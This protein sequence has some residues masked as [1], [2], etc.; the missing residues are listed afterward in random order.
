MSIDFTQFSK[1][2]PEEGMSTHQRRWW[3]AEDPD[4]AAAGITATMGYLHQ[5]QG[6]RL[7][8]YLISSRLYGNLAMMGIN[9]LSYNK[10]ASVQ[11]GGVK[12][13]ISFN[14]VQS[15]IDTITAKIAKNK[16]KPLFL[17][18]GGDYRQQKRAKR[19]NK[20]VEGLFYETDAYDIGTSAFRDAAVFG[21]GIIHVFEKN[22]RCAWERVIPS[23]LYVDEIE[24]FYGF[25]RQMHRAKNVDREMLLDLFGED[26]DSYQAIIDANRAKADDTQTYPNIADMVQVRESWHLPSGPGATDGKHLITIEGH[27][28]F[29][30]D[31]KHD[32]FPFAFLHWSK[33]LYGFW[34]QGLAE[35]LQSIQSEINKLLWVI[36]RSFHLAGT[37]KILLENSSK[38]VPEHL[39]NDIGAIIK[40]SGTKPDY[41]L[42]PMVQP[43][44][45]A[46][47]TTLK[48][49]AYE[50]AGISMLSANSQK[51]AGLNSGKALR[52]FNDIETE[53]FM[54]IGQNYER[55]Y[56][57]LAKLSIDCVKD[58][59]KGRKGYDVKAPTKKFI[60][61]IDWQDVKMEDDE[62]VMQVYPVSSL[63][64]DP[65]GRL[66]TISEY[67]QGGWLTQR[68]GRKLM[69]FPDLE[70]AEM[71]DGAAEEHLESVIES[72]VDDGEYTPPE[73]F[74]DLVMAMELGLKAY[75][76][77]KCNGLEEEKLELLRRFIGQAQALMAEANPPPPPEAQAAPPQAPPAAQ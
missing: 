36:Q 5:H 28:L 10:M 64:N 6:A 46:H 77:G 33:R 23:E 60:D 7:T 45:F 19:L 43:E 75:Q 44:I 74:D 71:L 40:Y 54:N 24:G 34:G 32:Y 62:Y 29:E 31:W 1:D 73:P 17:T 8:Q 68:Q 55:F 4:E 65:A 57:D 35:Q 70:A 2:G 58:I 42:P 52:E 18:S 20:F 49:S 12:D 27:C 38:V 37:F 69:D 48:Q 30:E 15:C 26:K 22:G 25:P 72:I 67:V 59:A 9:G 39:N 66:Q 50:Q 63:P 56:I 3:L 51:P 61:T 47:L 53:R 16:P 21:T 76:H 41:I 11:S 13:R 14:V